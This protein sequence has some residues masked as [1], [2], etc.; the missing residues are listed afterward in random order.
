MKLTIL[1]CYGPYPRARGACSGYLLE[2]VDTKILID[3]GNGVLSKLFTHLSD[4]NRLD[5]IIISHLHPDHMADLLVLRYKIFFDQSKGKLGQAVPLYIPASPQD[6]FERIQ[7]N[8]AYHIQTIQSDLL[9][10][11]K[12]IKIRFIKTDHPIECYGMSFEKGGKKLVYSGDTKYFDGL[13]DFAR[14][15]DLFLCDAGL[16]DRDWTEAAPHLSA[17]QAGKV[18]HD[19]QVKRLLLSHLYPGT[20]TLQLYNEARETFPYMIEVAEEKTYFV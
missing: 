16:T 17:R 15:S 13:L 8:Q 2:D 18:A 20:N 3:C 10:D 1:G 5:A 4:L 6:E 11:I 7:Y 12:G 9:L 19:A 14:G